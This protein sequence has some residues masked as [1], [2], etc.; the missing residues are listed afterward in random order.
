MAR[1]NEVFMIPTLSRFLA[2]ASAL[3]VSPVAFA[4][5]ESAIDAPARS[6]PPLSAFIENRGQFD[7]RAAFVASDPLLST[8]FLRDGF[9]ASLRD[10]RPEGR[11][12]N[13]RFSFE[14]ASTAT[15]LVGEDRLDTRFQFSRGNDPSRWTSASGYAG[16]RYRG[17]HRDLDLTFRHI[18]GK[19]E[20][21]VVVGPHADLR[22]FVVR[23]EGADRLSLG[24]DGSLQ[25]DTAAGR[26]VQAPPT[27]MRIDT[28]G[29][30]T[31]VESRF[32]VIDAERYG[33]ETG[34]TEPGDVLIVDPS[35][36]YSTYLAGLVDEYGK[37]TAVDASGSLTIVGLTQSADF[38]TTV[39]AFDTTHNGN[40]DGVIVKL[41]PTATAYVSATFFGGTGDD[42]VFGVRLDGSGNTYVTGIT[43][44]ANF[45]VT[46]GVLQSTLK[47]SSDAYLARFSPTG[48]LVYSTYL[49]GT[50]A[51]TGLDLALDSLG[52]ITVVGDTFSSDF[53]TTPG[54]YDTTYG[55]TVAGAHGDAFIA[56]LNAAGTALVSGTYIGGASDDLATRV[57]ID[58]TDRAVI[59]GN[60]G[61][62]TFP[63]TVGAFDTSFNGGPADCFIAAFESNG[64]LAFSTYVGGT[65]NDVGND[66]VVDPFGDIL[67]TGSVGSATYP[68][69]PGAYDTTFNGSTFD[70]MVSKLS[71]DGS[72]LV[73]ATFIGGAQKDFAYAIAVDGAG[74][75][76]ITGNTNSSDFPTTPGA[77]DTTINGAND[78][79]VAE[80]DPT[81][82]ALRYSTFIG[83]TGE[84]FDFSLALDPKCAVYISGYTAGTYPTTPGVVQPTAKGANDAVVSKFDLCTGSFMTYGTGCFGS[85]GFTPTLSGSG[86]AMGGFDVTVTIGNALGGST[87]FLFFGLGQGALPIIPTCSL[88]IAPIVPAIIIQVPIFGAGAGNGGIAL[89]A[90]LPPESIPFDIYIQAMIGDAGGNG[91]IS[92]SNALRMHIGP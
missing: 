81:G 78:L 82:A 37:A 63:V 48:T 38:P 51:E 5:N 9:V 76:Y 60:A 8:W 59:T 74:R 72:S 92:A 23:C 66:I 56:R 53:P 44:S 57:A 35:L 36:S 25:I 67:I 30:R 62:A 20:Y 17:V 46:V 26:L 6:I 50:G 2:T 11:G 65:G 55:G 22:S 14:G 61:N 89:T 7:A 83:G 47:G 4:A 54:A 41:N 29:I 87:A 27:T 18:D 32:R 85:G 75:A 69:T 68:V 1:T 80:F 73:Y 84:D 15:E 71:G 52:Q 28:H 64:A 90:T 42:R 13:L 19:I 21:D 91:G 39:G 10:P 70:G 79:Y 77:H 24:P 34:P 49:G 43:K 45:P 88:S 40:Y 33:F 58:S 16:V 86:C 31:P 3:F 12:A